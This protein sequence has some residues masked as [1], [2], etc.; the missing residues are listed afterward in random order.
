MTS[1]QEV[2][3]LACE[4][5]FFVSGTSEA[6]TE[7]KESRQVKRR[8]RPLTSLLRLLTRL[9]RLCSGRDT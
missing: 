4:Q 1:R 8:D 3:N 9:W 7:R 6:V 5:A 2:P